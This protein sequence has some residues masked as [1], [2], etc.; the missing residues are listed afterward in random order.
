VELVNVLELLLPVSFGI[1]AGLA[2]FLDPLGAFASAYFGILIIWVQG[3]RYFLMLLLFFF[4]ASVFTFIRVE[5]KRS[6]K[7]GEPE[8]GRGINPVMG[9]GML[10]CF[11]GIYGSLPLFVGSLAAALADTLA[12]EIGVF[13]PKPKLIL[14]L[15]PVSPGTRGAVS[16]LGGLGA[17][18]GALIVGGFSIFLFDAGGTILA[19]ALAAGVV[20][21]FVDSV[22]GASMPFLSKYEINVLS[23]LAGAGIGG[24]FILTGAV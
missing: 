13:H 20:G 14:G 8:R 10:P 23:T 1:L 18:T 24:L 19:V 21:S 15:R 3:I 4:F 2:R 9:K 11:F 12:T 7:V 6:I 22:L 5:Y 17:V 16:W